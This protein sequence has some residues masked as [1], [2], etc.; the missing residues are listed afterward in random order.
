[1]RLMRIEREVKAG[2]VYVSSEKNEERR[3]RKG[4]AKYHLKKDSEKLQRKKK[5][6]KATLSL[7]TL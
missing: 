1:M 3:S 5:A 4:D 2:K 7:L 6:D